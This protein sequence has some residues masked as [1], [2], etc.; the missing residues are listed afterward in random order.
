MD[1]EILRREL[2]VP[3]DPET[4]FE[5]VNAFTITYVTRPKGYHLPSCV[6]ECFCEYE[7]LPENHPVQLEYESRL[8]LWVRAQEQDARIG[9]ELVRRLGEMYGDTPVDPQE[10]RRIA[11]ELQAQLSAEEQALCEIAGEEEPEETL[12]VHWYLV[13]E[14]G[15]DEQDILNAIKSATQAIDADD[16][17]VKM[18]RTYYEKKRQEEGPHHE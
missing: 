17:H 11:A 8:Q 16:A 3:T 10:A 13:V 2:I 18:L 6:L 1:R 5:A 9:E 15:V 12:R 4:G 7:D 14:D